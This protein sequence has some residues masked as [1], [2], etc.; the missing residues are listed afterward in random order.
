MVAGIDP[1][2]F[3]DPQ[4]VLDGLE[5]VDFVVSL[6]TRASLVTERADVV[7]PVS[8]MHERAGS[9]VN[10]EGRSRPFDVVIDQPNGLSDLR[11]LAA[12]ADGL[13]ADLGFRTPAQ[14]RAELAE[15]GL[16]EGERGEAPDYP[17]GL[18]V[19]PGAARRRQHPG[20]AGHLADA[21]GREPGAGRR[22]DPAGHRPA[23]VARLSPATAAAA[24]DRRRTWRSP[25][26][27]ARSPCRWWSTRRW[28]TAWSGCPA[29]PPGSRCRAS[30][31][32]GR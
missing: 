2:D 4:A 9:F 16:W 23:P 11:V 26:T 21:P 27:A 1:T 25:T 13:G 14:A 10:W 28:S 6:E 17:A 18:A 30:G 24:A 29:G 8:L 20:R 31:G 22:P 19:E 12:L 7:L 5:E 32:R 15:L 3:A